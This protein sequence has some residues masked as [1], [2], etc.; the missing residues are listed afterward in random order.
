M[1]LASWHAPGLG[2]G[3]GPAGGVKPPTGGGVPR[4]GFQGTPWWGLFGGEAPESEKNGAGPSIRSI[5]PPGRRG[6]H[7][8]PSKPWGAKEIKA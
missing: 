7:L 1:S 5:I 3:L 8:K 4:G 2:T 6:L